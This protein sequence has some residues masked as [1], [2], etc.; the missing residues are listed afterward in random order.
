M[1]RASVRVET[2]SGFLLVKLTHMIRT[3]T[4]AAKA[5]PCQHR[6]IDVVLA[7]NRELYNAGLQAWRES[8]RR[9]L[10]NPLRDKPSNS[11]YD[12]GKILTELRAAD[13]A[14]SDLSVQ[15]GRGTLARLDKTIKHFYEGGGY[16]RFKSRDRWRCIEVAEASKSM[17]QAPANGGRWYR[18]KVKGLPELRFDA[19]R[20]EGELKQIRIVRSPL[21]LTV[22]V[23]CKVPDTEFVTNNGAYVGID[24]GV[25]KFATLSDGTEIPKRQLD[26]SRIKQLQRR[27]ARNKKGSNTRAKTK[28]TLAKEL[29]RQR[30]SRRC[31]D[32]RLAHDLVSNYRGIAVEDLRIRNMTRSARGTINDPG[33]NVSAKQALNDQII[34]QGWGAFLH[35]LRYKAEKAGIE[36]AKVNPAYT[37][38]VCSN[39]GENQNFCLDNKKFTCHSC[40]IVLDRDVNAAENICVRAFGTKPG[41]ST[42]VEGAIQV[43]DALVTDLPEQYPIEAAA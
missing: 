25:R 4:F 1:R 18:L 41:G 43:S 20:M 12:N 38:R 10:H 9:W 15:V 33:V 26:R 32:F 28:K 13:V 24:M 17:I 23:V 7:M 37:S 39:C 27:L 34:Q 8:F 35:I 19:S 29:A 3:F 30:E 21:R 16:P 40:Q 11:L 36:F 14:W 6:R 42:L 22:Q 5:S 31:A 2:N